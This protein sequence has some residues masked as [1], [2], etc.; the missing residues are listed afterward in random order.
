MFNIMTEADQN[1]LKEACQMGY[2]TAVIKYGAQMYRD[3]IFVGAGAALSGI[4]VGIAL[5]YGVEFVKRKIKE[6][7]NEA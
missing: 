7:K 2:D 5:N 1:E 3:G 4:I 6:C